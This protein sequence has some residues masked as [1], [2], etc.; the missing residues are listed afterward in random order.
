MLAYYGIPK[1]QKLRLIWH[2]QL[3]PGLAILSK[4]KIALPDLTKLAKQ[5]ND[6][7]AN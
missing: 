3:C 7:R 5:K 6:F 1:Q 4:K 2:S